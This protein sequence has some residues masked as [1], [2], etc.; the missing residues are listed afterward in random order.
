M[1]FVFLLITFEA[2]QKNAK[3]IMRKITTLTQNKKLKDFFIYSFGQAINILSPLLITPYIIYICGLEKLGIIAMGQSLAYILIVVVDYSSYIIGVKEI[4]IN[5]N[6]KE[7]LEELFK[8][9]YLSK[10]F[11]VLLVFLLVLSISLYVPYFAK[12]ALT[13]LLSFSII[14]GQFLNPTWFFQG[15]EN[16]KWITIINILSKT[17]YILGVFIFVKSEGDF[18]Y[19]NFWLG[20]GVIASSILGFVYI[21]K[22]YK[23][24]FKFISTSLVKDL[25][26]RD[27]SFCVSQLFFAIRNYSAVL[28][29]GFF[30]GD[31][32]A[33]QYKVIEQITNLFRTYLQMFFKFSY[34]YVCFEIDKS[35][36][37]GLRLWKRFNGCNFLLV[38]VLIVLV[39][40]FSQNVLVFF[41]VDKH[42]FNQLENYLHIALL[43]PLFTA[44]T[45]PLEQ[46]ILGLSK[47]KIYIK[48]TISMT[49]FNIVGIS[50]LM[51]S[52][53]L[54]QV[55]IL[56]ILTEIILIA[57]YL[58]ILKKYF[59]NVNNSE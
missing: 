20:F 10:L 6:N 43:I 59:V 48:L 11:L 49:I 7:K 17:I 55:F 13:I 36:A 34:S 25:L 15:V 44:I 14:F 30:A 1:A 29:I 47:N 40:V 50:I 56:L 53:G 28:I 37:K 19:A 24:T 35:L 5:R 27:F 42:I 45:L 52:F 54:T 12:N 38:L 39:Y 9:I 8:T 51:K 21:L 22:K 31:Y 33:G 16:F 3:T 26:I 2:G 18:V 4:S 46:L 41:K 32:I 58:S 57:I 23:F